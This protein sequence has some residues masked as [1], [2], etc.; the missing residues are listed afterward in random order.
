[1]KALLLK[2]IY[3]AKK[4]PNIITLIC[5]WSY[6]LLLGT[7]VA[8]TTEDMGFFLELL[9]PACM[10]IFMMSLIWSLVGKANVFWATLPYGK[11]ARASET[12]MVSLI[13]VLIALLLASAGYIIVGFGFGTFDTT[14]YICLILE[15]TFLFFLSAGSVGFLRAISSKANI[16]L[17]EFLNVSGI[18]CINFVVNKITLDTELWLRIGLTVF[19][20]IA[21]VAFWMASIKFYKE[22]EIDI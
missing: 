12:Y 13:V 9:Y 11:K 1:M 19:A 5:V 15:L 14:T 10:L 20:L 17:K 7:M 18:L 16:G 4:F 21:F 3:L 8:D 6:A 2:D 22:K